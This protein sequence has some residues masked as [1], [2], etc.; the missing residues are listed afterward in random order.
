MTQPMRTALKTDKFPRSK[1]SFR[2]YGGETLPE[3]VGRTIPKRV[4]AEYSSI[5]LFD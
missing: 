5:H 4:K 2:R 3:L 1:T